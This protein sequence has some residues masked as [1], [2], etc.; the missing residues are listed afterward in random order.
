MVTITSPDSINDVV[1]VMSKNVS[2][3]TILLLRSHHID[4][5]TQKTNIKKIKIIRNIIAPVNKA[6]LIV[7]SIFYGKFY[8]YVIPIYGFF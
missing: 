4:D 6:I 2:L 7:L 3:S 1:V 8:F 5:I